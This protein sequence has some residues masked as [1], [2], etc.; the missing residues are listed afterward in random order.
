MDELL[1]CLFSCIPG[2]CLPRLCSPA[3]FSSLLIS[4][5]PY[6]PGS[7]T[8]FLVTQLQS[9]EPLSTPSPTPSV[10]CLCGFDFYNLSNLVI[11]EGCGLWAT[12][13]WGS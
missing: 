12:S 2:A 3:F 9:H 4:D 6:L 10:A 11:L 8:H 7:P 13:L 5:Q 1:T